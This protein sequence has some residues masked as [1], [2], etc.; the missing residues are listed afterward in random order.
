MSP[1]ARMALEQ[2]DDLVLVAHVE[3]GERL[4][5][6]EQLG[7]RHEGLGDGH[8]LLLAAGERRHAPVGEGEWPRPTRGWRR[9]G[10]RSSALSPAEAPAA[11][12]E[13][14]GDEVAGPDGVADG[15]GVVLRHVAD[16][17]VAA[18]GV[19]A[20]HRA[21]TRPTPG[22]GRAPP[23]AAWSCPSRWARSRRRAHP[24][25]MVKSPCS[26]I[27][28]PP[29]ATAA[30]IGARS[31]PGR[32]WPA[33]D[34]ARRR[35]R[36]RGESVV[37]HRGPPGSAFSWS[38]CQATNELSP[39]GTDLGD[40]D[41][42]HV[43][44]LGHRPQ[45]LGERA[46]GLGVVDQHVDGAAPQQL[47]EGVHVGRGRVGLVGRRVAVALGGDVDQARRRRP[48]SRTP[49]RWRRRSCRWRPPSPRR[50]RRRRAAAR[51]AHAVG[52]LV[53]V[54]GGRRGRASPARR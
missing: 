45:L 44:V 37:S 41:D 29:R 23:G 51:S 20:E 26:Q 32:R 8:P 42:G 1:S 22:A 4:V 16:A 25:G 10:R 40:L 48:C 17:R 31:P 52:P 43:G 5:E 28:R 53:E 39:G 9:R 30:P 18:A 46:L 14:E 38:T 11:A 2:L 54:G 34:R 7:L 3:V 50:P 27:V 13:A 47:L 36:G 33:A 49:T 15:G 12:G 35:A 6:Q 19:V 21:P 24:R